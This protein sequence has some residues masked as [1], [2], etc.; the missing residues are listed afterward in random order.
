[1]ET[2]QVII[3]AGD[4]LP[5]YPSKHYLFA[6]NVVF[7]ASIATPICAA[8]RVGMWTQLHKLSSHGT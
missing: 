2:V 5:L 1:M 6:S 3:P 4:I 8:V 7:W